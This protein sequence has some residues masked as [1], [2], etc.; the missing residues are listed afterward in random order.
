M[1][2]DNT[3]KPTTHDT[4]KKTTKEE[5]IQTV[6]RWI[7]ENPE[8]RSVILMMAEKRRG[9]KP[10]CT[11]ATF[12]DDAA[13]AWMFTDLFHAHAVLQYIAESVLAELTR[14]DKRMEQ[15]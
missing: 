14:A 10:V 7:D 9:R 3:F 2:Q 15:K 13:A 6:K 12:T 11:N 1:K 8:D 4:M 5:V